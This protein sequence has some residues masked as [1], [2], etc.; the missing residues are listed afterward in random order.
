[1]GAGDAVVCLEGLSPPMV[2]S[3]PPLPEAQVPSHGQVTAPVPASAD[4]AR[5]AGK[6]THSPVLMHCSTPQPTQEALTNHNLSKTETVKPDTPQTERGPAADTLE[7]APRVDSDPHAHLANPSPVHTHWH[8]AQPTHEALSNHNLREPETVKLD[9]PQPESGPAADTLTAAP[10][11]DTTARAHYEGRNVSKCVQPHTAGE[12]R[13]PALTIHMR[14]PR[15]KPDSPLKA[16][17]TRRH[18][19]GDARAEP[20]Q[21]RLDTRRACAHPSGPSPGK[22]SSTATVRGRLGRPFASVTLCVRTPVGNL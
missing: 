4:G 1:M 6:A 15:T 2:C 21:R 17:T 7:K 8:T 20:R 9:T 11:A 5:N 12:E 18:M 10:R 19:T 22:Y 3:R 13:E 14:L 16:N